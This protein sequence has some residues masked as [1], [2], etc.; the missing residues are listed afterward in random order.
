[1]F[2][3]AAIDW[4]EALP[5]SRSRDDVVTVIVLC[6]RINPILLIVRKDIDMTSNYIATFAINEM[7]EGS[8][9]DCFITST[10]LTPEFVTVVKCWLCYCNHLS[11]NL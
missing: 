3:D 9:S 5:R 11:N 6:E 10:T 8:R 2:E 7:Q 4:V 1:M